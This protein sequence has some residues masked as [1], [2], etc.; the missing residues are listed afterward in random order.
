MIADAERNP[1]LDSDDIGS[2]SFAFLT[3]ELERFSSSPFECLRLPTEVR[4]GDRECRLSVGGMS[5]ES[6]SS[7]SLLSDEPA[8]LSATI[9]LRSPP[10]LL[11]L[12]ACVNVVCCDA[13]GV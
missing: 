6:I 3:A 11:P 12:V 4:I 8:D 7:M 1:S 2:I 10:S 13:L 5:D 9:C